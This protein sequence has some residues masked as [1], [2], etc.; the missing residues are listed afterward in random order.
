MTHSRRLRIAD[1]IHTT[2]KAVESARKKHHITDE[3]FH[4]LSKSQW[5][6]VYNQLTKRFVPRGAFPDGRTLYQCWQYWEDK[7]EV[8]Y[9]GEAYLEDLN[10]LIPSKQTVW[11][12]AEE[13]S[14]GRKDYWL[15]EGDVDAIYQIIGAAALYNYMIVSKK[16]DWILAE[17]QD[18]FLFGKGKLIVD[19]MISLRNLKN[20]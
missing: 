14:Y 2:R 5:R 18:G 6:S 11:L 3:Q 13:H 9:S 8:L 20:L 4:E 19:R 16:Y 12:L 1:P 10:V 17:D 7:Y 15:Y